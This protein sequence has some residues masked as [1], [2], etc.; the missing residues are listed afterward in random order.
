MYSFKKL[1]AYYFKPHK[2]YMLDF[3]DVD[4][5]TSTLAFASSVVSTLP[6][7]NEL[8]SANNLSLTDFA[9]RTDRYT[10]RNSFKVAGHASNN[11]SHYPFDELVDFMEHIC[12]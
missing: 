12:I 6:N 8:Q 11:L 10:S 4:L 5:V 3:A 9:Q 7:V 2:L 1:I